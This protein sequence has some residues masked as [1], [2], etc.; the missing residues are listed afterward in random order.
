MREPREYAILRRRARAAEER[1]E[2][3]AR[4]LE[5]EREAH[6]QTRKAIATTARE[7]IRRLGGVS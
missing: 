5:A 4:E 3:F 7:M 2:A 1:A 6:R